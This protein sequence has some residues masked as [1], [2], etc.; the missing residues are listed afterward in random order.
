MRIAGRAFD[1]VHAE[2]IHSAMLADYR[3]QYI[4]DSP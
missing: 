2:A 1:A 4:G 3:R